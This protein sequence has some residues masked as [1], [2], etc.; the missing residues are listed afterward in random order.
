MAKREEAFGPAQVLPGAVVDPRAMQ[1]EARMR[2]RR[3]MGPQKYTEPVAGGPTPPIPHLEAPAQQGMNMADQAN[4]QRIPHGPGAIFQGPTAEGIMHSDL[5][6]EAARQ[7]EAFRKGQ[8]EMFAANQPTSIARKYGVIRNGRPIPGQQLFGAPTA[9]GGALKAATVEGLEA[10]AKFNE[11]RQHVE[12]GDQKFE[13]EAAAGPAGAA[14][15]AGNGPGD[16]EVKPVDVQAMKDRINAMDDFDFAAF[17]QAMMKDL[18]NNDDQRKIIEGRLQPLDLTDLIMTGRCFQTVP[19][20]PGKFEP[21]F[22]SLT[23]EEDLALKRV[24]MEET[25]SLGA[26]EQYMLD[27]FS[28][29]AT[30][31]GVRS[32]NKKPLP[33]H[34]DDNGNF[35]DDLFRKKFNLVSKYPFHMIASLGLNWFWFD[36][37]VRKLFVAE[38]IKNG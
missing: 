15:A 14:A 1:H 25:R 17:R 4:Q 38:T 23:A 30:A 8:G 20:I 9:A 16:R 37:R 7:D 22:Q 12:S 19:V 21:E 35:N 36:V 11:Q 5:L 34:L 24:V 6:P 10:V 27:K 13:D 32:I 29:M 31:C 18:L 2:E 33:S 3:A 26:T 28:V